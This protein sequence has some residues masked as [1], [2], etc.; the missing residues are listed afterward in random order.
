MLQRLAGQG[1]LLHSFQGVA[2]TVGEIS[3]SPWCVQFRPEEN[4]PN[5]PC[6][7]SQ[8][9][10][11]DGSTTWLMVCKISESVQWTEVWTGGSENLDP[12]K[13]LVFLPRKMP[14]IIC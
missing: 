2:H 10:E 4:W 8:V 12:E 3:G 5:N 14:M 7:K 11:M 6:D 9:T 1:Q 13:N